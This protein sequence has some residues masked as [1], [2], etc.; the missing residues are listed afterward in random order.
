MNMIEIYYYNINNNYINMYN[1]IVIIINFNNKLINYL[2]NDWY[3]FI[4]D[5]NLII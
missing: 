2:I 4:Y 5:I 3:E 1:L